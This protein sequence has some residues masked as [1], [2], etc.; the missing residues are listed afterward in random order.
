[1]VLETWVMTLVLLVFKSG[2]GG[3]SLGDASILRMARLLRLTR[4][5]RM[6]RLLRTMPELMILIRGMVAAT[7]SVIFTLMLLCAFLYV[8][9]VAFRQLSD[10]T[11]VGEEFFVSVPV[12]M[13]TLVIHATFL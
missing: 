2:G 8:F 10:G 11:Q 13:H 1:M 12:A 3:A 9:A 4:M 5:A 7:R 6:A